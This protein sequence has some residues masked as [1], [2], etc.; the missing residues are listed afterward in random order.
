M[1]TSVPSLDREVAPPMDPRIKARRI[2]VRRGEG[3]RRLQRLADLGAVLLV[4]AAFAVAL[5]SPLLDV[6]RIEVLGASRTG[7]EAVLAGLGIRRGDQLAEVD[8]GAAGARVAALPWVAEVSL[9]RG[10]DGVVRVELT[11]RTPVAWVS[12]GGTEVLVDASGRVLG[13]RPEGTDF[14]PLVRVVGI[15]GPFEPGSHLAR[16][17]DGVLAVAGSLAAAVPGAVA[18]LRADPDDIS[19]LLAIGGEVRFGDAGRLDAKISSL[20]TM[21]EQ[22]DL[23]CLDELDLRLPGSPVLTRE[24]GCS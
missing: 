18:E 14:G 24:D 7:T 9:H 22:V 12:S 23:R 2:E 6:D 13:P 4:A 19:A 3:R 15:E 8:L 5:R 16:D 10:L 17:L 1:T 20:V 11:E 21:V